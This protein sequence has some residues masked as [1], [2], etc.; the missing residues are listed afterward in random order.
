MGSTEEL[1][2]RDIDVAF[3][4]ELARRKHTRELEF[5]MQFLSVVKKTTVQNDFPYLKFL[6]PLSPCQSE[7][8]KIAKTVI[9]RTKKKIFA[10]LFSMAR[11]AV[12]KLLCG[13]Q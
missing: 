6:R 10:W 4:F 9:R 2:Q 12:E 1:G 13:W 8:E 5:Y 3:D 11:Q 7:C